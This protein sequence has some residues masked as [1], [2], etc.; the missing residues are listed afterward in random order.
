MTKNIRVAQVK[1]FA[2]DLLRVRREAGAPAVKPPAAGSLSFEDAYAVQAAVALSM[3]PAGGF[4][5]ANKPDAPR[6]MAPIFAADVWTS[7]YRLGVPAGE[8]VGIELEVGFRIDRPLPPRD[9]PDRRTAVARC[10]S[11]LAAIEIVR[12]RLAEGADAVAK[13]ADNQ[14]NG[15]L[16]VGGAVRDWTALDLS[17]PRARLDLGASRV[18]DGAAGVPGGDAFENFLVLEEMVGVHCG[19]LKPGHVVITGSLNGLPYV[20]GPL[21]VSGSI[22]GLGPVSVEIERIG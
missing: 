2:A 19:G 8:P 20:D 10:I 7:P 3:G 11:A 1:S 18:L 14:I 5:V 15:G 22:E 17:R 21:C 13:L 6:I 9:A 12:T 16:V 4:K